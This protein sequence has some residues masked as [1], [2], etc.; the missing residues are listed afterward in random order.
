MSQVMVLC[1]VDADKTYYAQLDGDIYEV[2]L[3]RY[4]GKWRSSFY[5]LFE[6]V[7]K[8]AGSSE[9]KELAKIYDTLEDCIEQ[10]NYRYIDRGYDNN[11]KL[12]VED[13]VEQFNAIG[14]DVF[15]DRENG[16][17]KNY[18]IVRWKL[19]SGNWI[20]RCNHRGTDLT[21]AMDKNKTLIGTNFKASSGK[22]PTYATFAD[23]LKAKK[24]K[25]IVHTFDKE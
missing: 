17:I 20:V 15:F 11:E 23:A 16:E 1:S 25:V 21:F 13:Y 5:L 4:V 14:V 8:I 9:Y 19:D 7:F 18:Q 3:H 10:K 12:Q 6:P 2:K 24:N 22:E